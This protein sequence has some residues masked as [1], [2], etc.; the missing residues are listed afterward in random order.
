[1]KFTRVLAPLV[2]ALALA[3]AAGSVQAGVIV[4]LYGDVDG[5][6][7]SGGYPGTITDS[8]VRGTKTWTQTYAVSGAVVSATIEIGAVQLGAN[9]P[10]GVPQLFL[11]GNLVGALTD[12]DG[13]DG[14][15]SPGIPNN[16]SFTYHIDLLSIPTVADLS[17]GIANLSV[18]A[19]SGD[20]WLMDYS[21]ITITTANVPEPATLALLGLGLAGLAASRRR[22]Q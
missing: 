3:G 7:D 13:C 17:D 14:I 4:S 11:D 15:V 2:S 9:P 20:A 10:A 12:T 1:M 16:C 19:F 8:Y 21:R 22:K 5:T 6:Y 18:P